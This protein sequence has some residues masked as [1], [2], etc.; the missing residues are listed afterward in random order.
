[1]TRKEQIEQES[2]IRAAYVGGLEIVGNFSEDKLQTYQNGFVNGAEWA[3]NNPKSP[4]ISVEDDLPFNHE[5]L[6]D[7]KSKDM[8]FQVLIRYSDGMYGF[9]CMA[10]IAGEWKWLNSWVKITHWMKVPQIPKEN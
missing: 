5:E 6:V 2:A 4:W 1:M 8:T 9:S 7:S 10:D 3:D